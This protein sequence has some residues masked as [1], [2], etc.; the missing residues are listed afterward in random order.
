[1]VQE[2]FPLILYGMVYNILEEKQGAVRPVIKPC[3]LRIEGESS[4]DLVT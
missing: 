4:E 1:M 2:F 3:P